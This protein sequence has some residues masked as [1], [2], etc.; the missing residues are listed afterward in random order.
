MAKEF[1]FSKSLEELKKINSEFE[2]GDLDLDTAV[3]KFK[4]GLSLSKELKSHL[5]K[6]DNE[7]KKLSPNSDA[8]T[9][10]EV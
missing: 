6:I 2:S 8:E 7:V 4:D 1:N 10:G 9:I 3:E 5:E